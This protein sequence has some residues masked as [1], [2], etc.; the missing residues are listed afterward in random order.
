MP[1]NL[2]MA[3]KSK[4]QPKHPSWR[5]ILIRKKGER[6]GTVSA[7]DAESAIAKAIEVFHV[8][9]RYRTRLAATRIR[10]EQK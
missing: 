8:E 4:P 7:P 1:Q 10:D 6:L 3:R 9:E 2:A 5:I